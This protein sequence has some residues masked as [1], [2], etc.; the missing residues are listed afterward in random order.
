MLG[1]HGLLFHPEKETYSVPS[2]FGLEWD[3]YFLESENK[4]KIHVWHLKTALR[5]QGVIVFSH[6][7]AENLS[8]HYRALAWVV[9]HGYDL[10][11]FDYQGFGESE[12]KVNLSRSVE[13]NQT[14]LRWSLQ[15]FEGERIIFY[16]Q[17]IGAYILMMAIK[18]M[19]SELPDSMVVLEGAFR[20]PKKVGADLLRKSWIT[21]PLQWV[22]YVLLPSSPENLQSLESL[23]RHRVLLIHGAED[24]TIAPKFSEEIYQELPGKHERWLVPGAGHNS[25]F[26]QDVSYRA[27]FIEWLD[28]TFDSTEKK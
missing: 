25:I 18:A 27:K 19:D 5:R 3:E 28:N 24:R 22:P 1:C 4:N 10:V 8:S 7:N 23:S 9:E 6:G 15:E 12:G 16:G 2:E 17:S 20:S 14:I 11:I 21:W 13:D 26:W